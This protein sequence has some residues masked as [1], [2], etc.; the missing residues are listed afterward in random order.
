MFED[1]DKWVIGWSSGENA[2]VYSNL[3]GGAK[4]KDIIIELFI[5]ADR[6]KSDHHLLNSLG[7]V[8]MIYTEATKDKPFLFSKIYM[9]NAFNEG[10]VVIPQV[11]HPLNEPGESDFLGNSDVGNTGIILNGGQCKYTEDSLNFVFKGRI[12]NDRLVKGK[13]IGLSFDYEGDFDDDTLITGDINYQF[14]DNWHFK[15]KIV[16]KAIS[17]K[18]ELKHFD[19]EGKLLEK[20]EGNWNYGVHESKKY[21]I[22]YGDAG[23]RTLRL[24]LVTLREVDPSFDPNKKYEALSVFKFKDVVIRSCQFQGKLFKGNI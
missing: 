14:V 10:I 13:T 16:K 6:E 20:I 12:E 5:Y 8:K 4:E 11:E 22:I 23:E 3:L 24:V 17:G 15:G 9:S 21:M 19:N 2:K 7:I 1:R 18:G